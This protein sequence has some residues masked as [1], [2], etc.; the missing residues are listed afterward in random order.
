M[1][2]TYETLAKVN[3]MSPVADNYSDTQPQ[4]MLSIL[5]N[6]GAKTWAGQRAFFSYNKDGRGTPL[7]RLAERKSGTNRSNFDL[8]GKDNIYRNVKGAY[9]NAFIFSQENEIGK[10]SE[11]NA[12]LFSDQNKVYGNADALFIASN[13]NTIRKG[14]NHDVVNALFMHTDGADLGGTKGTIYNPTLIGSSYAQVEGVTPKSFRGTWIS[15]PCSYHNMVKDAAYDIEIGNY[16]GYTSNI[17]GGIVMLGTG[18]LHTG[19]PGDSRRTIIGAWNR[20]DADPDNVFIVGDGFIKDGVVSEGENINEHTGLY[21][22][23]DK[24]G[25]WY[26]HNLFVV[27]RQGWAGIYDYDNPD[28]NNARYAFDGIHATINGQEIDINFYELKSKMAT[29]DFVNQCESKVNSLQDSVQALRRTTP[30]AAQMIISASE[31]FPRKDLDEMNYANGTIITIVNFASVIAYIYYTRL[32][33][34][35][36]MNRINANSSNGPGTLTLMR[37][38]DST[39][40]LHGFTEINN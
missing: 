32:D 2:N 24:N 14:V 37:I 3:I 20:D 35:R 10:D 26:R 40:N 21:G 31:T 29:S 27:N 28:K 34:T 9:G 38:D 15:S 8:F 30:G 23:G 4:L 1:A 33:G 19:V 7:F 18:L 22:N 25:D 13:L 16:L 5:N 39:N 6:D 11:N 36:F 17:K 12:F